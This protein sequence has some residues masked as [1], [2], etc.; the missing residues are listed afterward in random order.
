MAWPPIHPLG[1]ALLAVAAL[2]TLA[3]IL[4]IVIAE[5][6]RFVAWHD[7]RVQ[8]QEI[9]RER[10]RI[11]LAAQGASSPAQRASAIRAI[12]SAVRQMRTLEQETARVT[13]AQVAAGPFA[14]KAGRK[15]A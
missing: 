3:G 12:S 6:A 1:L 15:A 4:R 8:C 2:A 10:L 7:L 9:R 11:L 5:Y 14:G 13:A